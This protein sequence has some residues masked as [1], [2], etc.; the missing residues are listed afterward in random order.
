[1]TNLGFFKGWTPPEPNDPNDPNIPD[2]NLPVDENIAFRI[3]DIDDNNEITIEP[4]TSITLYLRLS[5][6]DPCGINGFETEIQISD[7]NL[8]EM[9]NREYSGGDSNTWSNSTA[10]ILATPRYSYYDYAGPGYE[11]EAGIVLSAIS[12]FAG[13][14]NDGN[15]AS[16]V[17]TCK[18]EGD[19]TLT[20]LSYNSEINPRVYSMVIHQTGSQ[21]MMMPGGDNFMSLQENS[22]ELESTIEESPVEQ[23]VSTAEL[24]SW[25]ENLRE[26]DPNI[27]QAISEDDWEDFVNSIQD[28]NNQ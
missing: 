24:V 14:I 4:D 2:P 7:P 13:D 6:N 1:L 3:V 22:L 28:S 9:D 25:L 17:F 15:L 8:G 21:Q 27:S 19:V 26:T 10:R 16:F 18:G 11:Q 5:T 20:I 23:V 12:M